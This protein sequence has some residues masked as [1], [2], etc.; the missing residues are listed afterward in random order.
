MG[1]EG[2]VVGHVAQDVAEEDIESRPLSA[3]KHFVMKISTYFEPE[4]HCDLYYHSCYY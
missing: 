1:V 2:D 4:I 3:W